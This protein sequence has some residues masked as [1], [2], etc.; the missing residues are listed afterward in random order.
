[1]KLD[2]DILQEMKVS[3]LLINMMVN[4]Q[5]KYF[6]EF[7]KVTKLSEE[8]FYNIV[9]SFRPDHLWEKKGND[10]RYGKNWKLKEMVK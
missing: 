8:E 5:K 1:M 9:D 4:S 6:Q 10:F 2:M 7:L 3:N